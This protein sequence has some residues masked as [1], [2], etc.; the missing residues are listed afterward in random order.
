MKLR[1]FSHSS[2]Q[3]TTDQGVILL[4]DPFLDGNPNSPVSSD[5]VNADYIILTHGHGDHLGDSFKIA[6]RTDPLFICVNELA[7]YV[8][9][10]GFRAHNMHI[11]GGYNFDFG[12]LKFTIAHHG[13]MTPDNTY[14][15]EPAGV[16]LTCGST[17]IYHT[18]DTGLFY[19]MKLIGEMTRIDY[20][21]API[22]DN[23]T[24]GIDDAVKAVEL[25]DPRVVI[26]MHYNTFPVIEADPEE[27]REKVTAIGKKARIMSFGEEIEL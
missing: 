25:V 14:A 5:E 12:R 26:P 3:I 18:G 6:G 21:L 23:F 22:G 4:I 2:F 17:S 7:N 15:G 9:A 13:S 20:M 1:Y 10:K 8:A 16:V 11:G 19:D 24:M 27:F